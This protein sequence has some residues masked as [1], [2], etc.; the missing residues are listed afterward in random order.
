MQETIQGIIE[1]A[2]ARLSGSPT[3]D[4]AGAV[5]REL[6][7]KKGR[8]TTLLRSLKDV[9]AE[10]RPKVGQLVNA[11]RDEITAL[12][13]SA[14][15]TGRRQAGEC[16]DVTLPGRI[17]RLG[18]PHVLW[19]ALQEIIDI[20]V[21][22]G[23]MVVEGPEIEDDWHNFTALNIPE[24]HPAKNECFR[25]EGGLLLRTETSAVQ[26]R[27]MEHQEPP[28]RILCPGRVYRPDTVDATHMHTF[29]QV[30]GLMVDEGISFADLKGV[31]ALYGRRAFGEGIKMRFRPDY[32]P[33]VEPGGE[34]A[35]TCRECMGKG[36]SL[37]KG[38]GWIEVGGCGMVHPQVLAN[39]G[40]DP[41]RYTGFAFGLGIE[42]MAMLSYKIDDIRLFLDNDVRFLSQFA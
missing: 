35:Y 14:L 34:V 33:F 20:F 1:E 32:F 40:Y 10:E 17:Q 24:E 29:H 19:T 3:R 27:T 22:M 36:C 42:R 13:E 11:A 25:F 4:E 9:P 23:F 18:A 41:E 30:E 5:E 37:C 8:L 2:R 26:I 31:L 21:G 39:V 38:T 28:V 12:L 7:G 15:A 6:L 16:V